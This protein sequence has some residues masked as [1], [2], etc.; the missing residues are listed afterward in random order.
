[1]SSRFSVA[2]RE[3]IPAFSQIPRRGGSGKSGKTW[4][5][6]WVPFFHAGRQMSRGWWRDG[7]RER[8]RKGEG[9]CMASP[10]GGKSR[11]R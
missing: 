7:E 4:G 1:M 6:S 8:E 3:E 9:G 10:R 2:S 11:L 5:Q